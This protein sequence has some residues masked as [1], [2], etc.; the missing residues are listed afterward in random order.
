MENDKN[1][2]MDV[3]DVKEDKDKS[4]DLQNSK[5]NIRISFENNRLWKQRMDRLKKLE[6]ASS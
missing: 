3:K 6:K 4:T 1:S 5:C 2:K